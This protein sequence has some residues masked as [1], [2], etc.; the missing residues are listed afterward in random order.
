MKVSSTYTALSS[1]RPAS[2]MLM[3]LARFT[4]SMKKVLRHENKHT[5]IPHVFVAK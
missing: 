4:C 1:Q 2:I 3:P 5:R